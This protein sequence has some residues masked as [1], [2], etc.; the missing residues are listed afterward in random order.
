MLRTNEG[1]RRD[2]ERSR[3]S[4]RR[5]AARLPRHPRLGAAATVFLGG[6]C[7]V[8]TPPAIVADPTPVYVLD[9]GRH[10][11]LVLPNA[12]GLGLVEFAYGEWE[13]FARGNDPW[14]RVPRVLFLPG[15]GTLGRRE[16]PPTAGAGALRESTRVEEVLEVRVERARVS[17]L[18]A[19]LEERHRSAEGAVV[20][21]PE[22]GLDF[23]HDDD[24]YWIL[25]ECNAAVVEWLR[26]LG[27]SVRG[28]SVVACFEVRSPAPSGRD[29]AE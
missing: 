10:S 4:G 17:E 5:F 1:G 18:E 28:R 22:T 2:G 23:V 24:R 16:L 15:E 13:W 26:E 12:E 3:T 6:C 19:R 20:H 14:Y 21:N 29:P 25:H 27:A 8:V 11:S 7:S 9:Y